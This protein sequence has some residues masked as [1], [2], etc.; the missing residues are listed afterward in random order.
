MFE[1]VRQHG[2]NNHGGGAAR[3]V[4]LVQAKRQRSHRHQ[5]PS[6]RFTCSCY[7]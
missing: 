2:I 5:N 3:S 1:A 7:F 6:D 4:T